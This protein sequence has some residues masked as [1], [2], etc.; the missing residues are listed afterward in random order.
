MDRTTMTRLAVE[1]QELAAAD[2][3]AMADSEF[4]KRAADYIDPSVAAAEISA[5]F[6]R[7]PTVVG[8]RSQLTEPGD[9]FTV[10]VAGRPLLVVLQNDGSVQ[11]M[12]N[13][14]RHRGARVVED[15]SGSRHAFTCRYHAWTYGRGGDLMVIPEADGFCNIELG[16]RG[17]ELVETEVRHGLIW[18]LA[19]GEGLDVATYLG[20]LDAEFE[21]F[22]LATWH[23]ERVDEMDLDVNWKLFVDGFLELYHLPYLHATTVGLFI[24]QKP[25]LFEAAGPHSRS[26]GRR[27]TLNNEVLAVD[28]AD[29]DLLQHSV[30]VYQL[31]PNTVVIWQGDHFEVWTTFPDP[32]DPSRSRTRASL[33]APTKELAEQNRDYWSKN[34]KLLMDTVRDEDLEVSAGIQANVA[35]GVQR[36]AIFGRNEPALQHFHKSVEASIAVSANE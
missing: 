33:L 30:V 1:M 9:Y 7:Q 14:C 36:E 21:S 18:V 22:G 13:V 16:D 15:T 4:F 26:V 24:H 35:S 10:D 23:E 2:S 3:T 25:N 31:F 11:A 29:L 8:H 6:N 34:W 20:A 32:T 17:L 27:R 28:P 19:E 12:L 5:L